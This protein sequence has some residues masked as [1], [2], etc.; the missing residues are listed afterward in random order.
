MNNNLIKRLKL[1]Y[2]N[3]YQRDQKLVNFQRYL[4]NEE[5]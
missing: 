1:I 4:R 3:R 2:I 5:Y